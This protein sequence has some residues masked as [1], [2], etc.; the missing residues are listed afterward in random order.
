MRRSAHLSDDL[1]QRFWLERAWGPDFPQAAP[2]RA[3]LW[4]MHNPSAA[5]AE[6]DDPTIRR[7][8]EFTQYWGLTRALVV[9]LIPRISATPADAHEWIDG[10]DMR[11]A[12]TVMY[13]R[14]VVM[15]ADLAKVSNTYPII[16]AAWGGIARGD[17]VERFLRE[18]RGT[19]LKLNCI[20]LT[21]AGAPIH[22]LARGRNRPALADP[23]LYWSPL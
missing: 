12:Q 10:G 16:V 6:K 2:A 18:W 19:G 5:D 15:L 9:N 17:D 21:A 3:A 14:T 11:K 22:P 13:L 8:I 23:Q 1:T 20:G 4:I 7:V